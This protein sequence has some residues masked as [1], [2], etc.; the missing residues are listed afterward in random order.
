M[1]MTR[2]AIA[3]IAAAT[4]A[5]V[6]VVPAAQAQSNEVYLRNGLLGGLL[7]AGIGAAAG[8]GRGAGIGGAIGLGL[9]LLSTGLA[10]Q[11][12]RGGYSQDDLNQ[13]TYAQQG[14]VQ[15]IESE[16][17]AM[18]YNP[19]PVDGQYTA[20]TRFAIENFQRNSGLPVDGQPSQSL[21][22]ELQQQRVAAYANGGP[23]SPPPQQFP[24]G[25]FQPPPGAQSAPDQINIYP[26]PQPQYGPQSAGASQSGQ[27]PSGAQRS[28]SS[29]APAPEQGWCTPPCQDER[30]DTFFDTKGTKV[31]EY[32]VASNDQVQVPGAGLGTASSSGGRPP[33]NFPLQVPPSERLGKLPGAAGKSSD[34]VAGD[35]AGAG[36]QSQTDEQAQTGEQANTDAQ[37][38]GSGAGTSKAPFEL[39]SKSPATFP[40]GRPATGAPQTGAGQDAQ[41]QPADRPAIRSG[42]RG[43]RVV[44]TT[45]S[46]HQLVS[47]IQRTLSR[48]GYDPGPVD[49][50]HG[51]KTL[52]A[53]EDFERDNGLPLSGMATEEV[54]RAMQMEVIGARTRPVPDQPESQA[55]VTIG[56]ENPTTEER[57]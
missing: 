36:D 21:L 8:G 38:A 29:R 39:A 56:G 34:P 9:G 50:V 28:G 43:P 53:I 2:K 12:R 27:P 33:P 1:A 40:I 32:N 48:L 22:Q 17:Q 41:S 45:M 47:A 3:A 6:A 15:T 14:L 54:L 24:Q 5:S 35:Q 30:R 7:G 55:T 25:G 44:A 20:E 23:P 4:V 10:S 51:P 16:L 13:Q 49:G 26:A 57:I 42:A 46:D 52:R 31:Q 18:G 19:G 37:N 11:G